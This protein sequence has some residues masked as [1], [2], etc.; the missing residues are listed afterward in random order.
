MDEYIA[1]DVVNHA[2]APGTPN[3]LCGTIAEVTNFR[4]V[5]PDLQVQDDDVNISGDKIV[6]RWMASG[7]QQGTMSGHA[8]TGARLSYSGIDILHV[9]D[10]KIVERWSNTTWSR[11]GAWSKRRR[12]RAEAGRPR[13]GSGP[14]MES[15][16]LLLTNGYIVSMDAERRLFRDGTV[17]VRDDRIL[18]VGRR[19]D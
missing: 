7:T 3:G 19:C 8:P 5:V 14:G 9:Q 12:P 6:L 15:S 17:V 16:T 4:I 18:A 13:T 11:C 10:A 2:L 1:E